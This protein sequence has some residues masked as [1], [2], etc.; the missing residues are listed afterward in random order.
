MARADDVDDVS[1]LLGDMKQ[2]A[3]SFTKG[4][5]ELRRAEEVAAADIDDGVDEALRAV[6]EDAEEPCREAAEV[7]F[8]AFVGE[9]VVTNCNSDADMNDE[10]T[11]DDEG[12]VDEELELPWRGFE[13][14]VVPVFGI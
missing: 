10:G 7:I 4:A 2:D 12:S 13:S 3:S 5:S 11:V 8:K 1:S 6:A 14:A 9:V